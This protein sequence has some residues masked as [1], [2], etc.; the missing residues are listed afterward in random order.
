MTDG[1]ERWYMQE[2]SRIWAGTEQAPA[3]RAAMFHPQKDICLQEFEASALLMPA[4]RR[5][6][7][8]GNLRRHNHLL[9][10]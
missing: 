7:Q 5:S 4:M 6:E 9:R 8:P 1:N 10:E 3:C 2:K